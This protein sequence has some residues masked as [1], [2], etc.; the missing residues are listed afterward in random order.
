MTGGIFGD[1]E[2]GGTKNTSKKWI[3]HCSYTANT[4]L[5][6]AQECLCWEQAKG[7]CAEHNK[8]YSGHHSKFLIF[9]TFAHKFA[10]A[11]AAQ[12]IVSTRCK[13]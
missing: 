8:G 2:L 4:G 5:S 7:P 13:F 3:W 9:N 1:A 6:W 12:V 10:C 11:Q